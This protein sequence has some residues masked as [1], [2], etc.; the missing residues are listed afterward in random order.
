MSQSPGIASLGYL[1]TQ[2][3]NPWA[4]D[5]ESSCPYA[6]FLMKIV[7]FH[8]LICFLSGRDKIHVHGKYSGGNSDMPRTVMRS[9][10][11]QATTDS[12]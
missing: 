3:C 6:V 4:L 1:S 5:C 10:W 12:V 2:G 9:I 8:L 7:L 11:S